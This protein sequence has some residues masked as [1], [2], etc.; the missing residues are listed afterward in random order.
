MFTKDPNVSSN[1]VMSCVVNEFVIE[2][3]VGAGT[4]TAHSRLDFDFSFSF[5]LSSFTE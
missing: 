5:F 2:G 1:V 3:Q 4:K